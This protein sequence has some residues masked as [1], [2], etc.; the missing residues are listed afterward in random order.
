LVDRV[1]TSGI[2]VRSNIKIKR[3]KDLKT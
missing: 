1:V 3:K 2:I